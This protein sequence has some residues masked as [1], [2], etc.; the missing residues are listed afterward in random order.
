MFN[1]KD[2][3][4]FIITPEFIL[5]RIS[6]YDI[7]KYYCKN[8]VEIGKVFKS[9]LR[10]DRNPSCSISMVG[11]NLFYKDFATGDFFNCFK[12]VKVKY[13]CNFNEALTIISNDFNLLSSSIKYNV[14]KNN[15]KHIY[16]DII[17]YKSKETIIKPFYRSWNIEDVKYWGKYSIDIDILNKYNVYPCKSVVINDSVYES[18]KS[19]LI[20]VYKFEEDMYKVYRPLNDKYRWFSN[21]NKN[22]IQGINNLENKCN[23]LIIT[24]SL[25]DVICYRILGINA[26]AP[27]S[28][29][30]IIGEDIMH[31]LK[32]IS[33]NIIVN[34]D[35]DKTGILASEQMCKKY[36]LNEFFIEGYKDI[37]DYIM[38]EGIIKAKEY[39]NNKL[40]VYA[41]TNS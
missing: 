10:S 31:K 22:V 30:S 11:N 3:H 4:T 36:N 23:I 17:A 12:Y 32:N 40:I 24:K 16:S 18:Y 21:T 33:D 35:G 13:M 37:S 39:I 1:F 8:F 28:E 7:F 6:Q 15:I 9:E 2:V 38:N 20:Y 27:Q 19:S 26:I 34:Y 5:S 41:N 25:K 14:I 29:T